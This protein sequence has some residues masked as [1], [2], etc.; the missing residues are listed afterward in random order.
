M[1]NTGAFC[2]KDTSMT[3]IFIVDKDST[4]LM[5]KKDEINLIQH[6]ESITDQ[7][8]DFNCERISMT[9][10]VLPLIEMNPDKTI[11]DYWQS[12]LLKAVKKGL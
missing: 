6:L 9:K 1:E 7:I 8:V 10:G 5:F 12:P 4:S 2:E 11:I 3:T